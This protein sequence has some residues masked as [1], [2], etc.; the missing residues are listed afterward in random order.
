MRTSR[1]TYEEVSM[2]GVK[3]V[4][5]QGGCGRKLKRQKK[6]YQTLNPFNKN[7]KG[8][9]KTTYEIYEELRNEIAEWRT[10]G[11][12]CKHCYDHKGNH[13]GR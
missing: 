8:V 5:C 7:K 9:V 6:F 2:T 13:R 4:S 1:V 12:I 3:T 11:E 10:T